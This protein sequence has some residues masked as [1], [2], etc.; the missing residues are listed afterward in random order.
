[1]QTVSEGEEKVAKEEEEEVVAAV[2]REYQP[3]EKPS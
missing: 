3:R 1:M 2:R